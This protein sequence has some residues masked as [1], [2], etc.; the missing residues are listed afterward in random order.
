MRLFVALAI[1][2]PLRGKLDALIQALRAADPAPRWVNS[3]NLHITLK[4]IGEAPSEKL[5]QICEALKTVRLACQLSLELRGL[6]FF[7]GARR[8]AVLWLGLEPAEPLVRLAGEI[9]RALAMAGIPREERPFV[10][11]LTIARFKQPRVSPALAAQI[12]KQQSRVFGSVATSE[13]HL[14]ESRLQPGGAEYTTLRSF[15]FSGVG[16]EQDSR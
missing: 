1:S 4:F 12:E 3:R 8:P 6:A 16:G 9:D 15:A 7:P 10:A 13:L 2:E 11:H 5:P 14:M